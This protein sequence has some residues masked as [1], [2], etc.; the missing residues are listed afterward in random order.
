MASTAIIA[1]AALVAIPA[2]AVA[3]PAA[4]S[5]ES[6]IPEGGGI[7]NGNPNAV[8]GQANV[9]VGGNFTLTSGAELEGLLVV[10]GNATFGGAGLYNAG[11]VGVGSLLTPPPMSDMVLVGGD[12]AVTQGRQLDVGHAIGGGVRVGGKLTAAPNAIETNGAELVSNVGKAAALGDRTALGGVIAQQSKAYAAMKTT[13]TATAEYGTLTL[14]GDG[15]K[16]RQVFSLTATEVAAASSL[17]YENI[18][19]EAIVVVNVV[20]DVAK[21]NLTAML[22]AKGMTMDPMNLDKSAFGAL[23]QRLLWNF[24]TAKDVVIG[25]TAQ[26]PGSVLV[27]NPASTTAVKV[28]GTNGRMWVAGNLVHDLGTGSEIHAF[29]FLDGDVFGCD[30]TPPPSVELAQPKVTQAVCLA[31]GKVSAPKVELPTSSTLN[32]AL[33][34]KVAAGETVTVTATSLNGNKIA[35]LVG[36]TLASDALSATIK[37]TLDDVACDRPVAPVPPTVTQAVCTEDGS[38]TAPKVTVAETAGV[39]Y[40]VDGDVKAG[41]TVTITATAD[42][43]SFLTEAEGWTLAKDK[44]TATFTVELKDV[45]CDQP[46]APVAPTVTQA[47]CTEDGSATAPKV[48]VAETAGVTY[49]VAGDVKAGSTVTITATADE[50]SF[51]TEAEGW[52]L[53]KDKKTATFTVELADTACDQPVAPVAPTVTQAVCTEDGSATAPKVTVAETAGITYSLAGDVKAGSTVTI[54][55]TA[56]KGSFL[57]PAKGWTVADD[58]M[59]ATFTVELADTACDQP[60]TPVMPR[61]SEAECTVSGAPTLPAVTP[62]VSAGISYTIEGEPVAGGT[63]T[64]TA[65]AVEGFFLKVVEGWKYAADNRSATLTVSFADLACDQPVAPVAPI[66]DQAVCTEE[67]SATAPTVTVAETVGITYEVAGEVKAGSTVTV[68]ATANAGNFLEE[69]EGWVLSDDKKSATFTVDLADI[70]CDQPVAPVAPVA[71]TVTQAVCTEDGSA[72]LP[73]ITFAETVG[74]TYEVIG[75]VLPGKSVKVVAKP[76][77]GFFF[78]AA[79]GWVATDAGAEFT[80]QLDEVDC[81]TIPVKPEPEPTPVPEEKSVP[82]TDLAVSG[83]GSLPAVGIG[84]AALLILGV[85]ALLV[86]RARRSRSIA[87]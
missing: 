83:A 14:K 28:P 15:S 27:A 76:T 78:T 34:G 48:T 23:T 32:Y 67:G 70:A 3:A 17:K 61:I 30:P 12:M 37:I 59:T 53:A 35:A 18:N 26:F 19:P 5:A 74:A 47:V 80:V 1:G 60:G 81:I 40:S 62:V 10:E 39:T 73:T 71:P 66:V 6:C 63:V 45:A 68:T 54:T 57:K 58:K 69:V 21:F 9:Y 51:L 44:K 22:N 46:V 33:S 41:S 13:G 16:N 72:T 36:W 25:G 49:E 31:D 65:T 86:T 84:A 77:A 52:T 56:D 7:G 20:G 87:E 82:P 38:A 42:E 79:D 64:V 43:G 8:D 4:N 55:A 50:G 2:A 11:V 29:P 24:P 85:S 75:E